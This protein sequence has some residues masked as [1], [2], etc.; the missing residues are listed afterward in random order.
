M[1]QRLAKIRRTPGARHLP[2][3]DPHPHPRACGAD[4]RELQDLW[5]QP[6]ADARRGLW[7]RVDR[8]TDRNLAGRRRHSRRHARPSRRSDRAPRAV[9]CPRSRSS[10]STRST[11]CSTWASSMPSAR[12]PRMLPKQRQNLFFS[13][14]MPKEIAGLAAALLHR[15]GAGRGGAGRYH[16]RDGQPERHPCRSGGEAETPRRSS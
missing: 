13:A 8:Q 14:T 10:S 12:S 16:G 6:E 1:L 15:S 9:T 3:A 2:R 7:R 11:R 4:R 5:P